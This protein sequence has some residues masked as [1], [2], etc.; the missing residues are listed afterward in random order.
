MSVL[1]ILRRQWIPV[2][3]IT[4][5]GIVAA[6][7]VTLLLPPRYQATTQVMIESQQVGARDPSFQPIDMTT[8][9][10]SSTVIDRTLR[11]F[12]MTM[13][14]D[15]F[16]NE[17]TAKIG[18]DSSVMPIVYID[19]KPQRA[20]DVANALA[21]N[22]SEYYREITRAKY[23]NL[24]TYLNEAM[25]KRRRELNRLD[26]ELQTAAAKDPTLAESDALTSLTNRLDALVEK[27]DEE[28]ATL[29]GSQ[30]EAGAASSQL[31]K[32]MPLVHQE[33][34]QNDPL[35]RSLQEQLGKDG[36]NLEAQRAQYTSHFPGLAGLKIRVRKESGAIDRRANQLSAKPPGGS[37]AYLTALL[38]QNH[39]SAVATG[40]AA[41]VGALE[42]EIAAV[43]AQIAAAPTKGVHLTEVRRQHDIALSAYQ[44]LASR[45]ESV[46]AEQAQAASLGTIDV[47]DR[48]ER[49][50][51]V[52][53]KHGPLLAAGAVLGFIILAITVAFLLE[54]VDRRLRTVESITDLYGK[55][56]IVTLRTRRQA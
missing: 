2:T 49:A 10:E 17:I 40:D 14:P 15:D 38:A 42:N 23:D 1:Q 32:I 44:Q 37:Q 50:Y 24:T 22:L 18:Y 13:S 11:E 35:Y 39:A 26:R 45:R 55:P 19:A 41:R 20:V 12:H 51:P 47:V 5:V 30:A 46:L 53:G 34:A 43:R 52:V 6:I 48:A 56:V 4:L 21:D 29:T 9:L 54:S 3:I 27:H 36:T 16:I 28:N 25:Q 31:G 7:A 33:I 8:L